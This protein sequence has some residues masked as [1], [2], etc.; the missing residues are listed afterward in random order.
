M[1]STLPL[2]KRHRATLP[3]LQRGTKTALVPSYALS[4]R[5]CSRSPF[6]TMPISSEMVVIGISH[7]LFALQL[8]THERAHFAFS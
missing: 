8:R 2:R 6:L 7:L 5:G 1:H 4:S 3:H